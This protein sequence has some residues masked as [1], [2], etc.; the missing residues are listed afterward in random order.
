[1]GGPDG[2]GLFIPSMVC[3]LGVETQPSGKPLL[4]LPVASFS[5]YIFETSSWPQ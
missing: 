2:G 3:H 1:M 4:I 5:I